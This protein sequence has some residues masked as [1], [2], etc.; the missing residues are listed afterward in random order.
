MERLFDST[1]GVGWL[2]S[3]LGTRRGRVTL[4]TLRNLS[5]NL[6][7]AFSPFPVSCND[8]QHMPWMFYLFWMIGKEPPFLTPPST[9]LSR[10]YHE[11]GGLL[12][13]YITQSRLGTLE[14]CR[15]PT[16][17]GNGRASLFLAR[18]GQLTRQR[19]QNLLVSWTQRTVLGYSVDRLAASRELHCR[20]EPEICEILG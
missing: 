1:G 7:S 18:S 11:S 19:E 14:F 8:T 20:P 15:D 16:A 12:R 17:T 2:S 10:I 13:M 5:H 3:L 4:A 9:Q 6:R